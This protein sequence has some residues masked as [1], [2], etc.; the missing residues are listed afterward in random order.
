MGYRIEYP[1]IRKLRGQERQ[2]SREAALTGLVFLLFLALVC[3]FWPQGKEFLKGLVF[4]GNW[5][6]TAG[7][8]ED[9]VTE[10]GEGA[11]FLQALEGFCMDVVHHVY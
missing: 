9:M 3:S 7:A 2:R 6:V 8:L 10:L 4:S 11:P 5:S 1:P